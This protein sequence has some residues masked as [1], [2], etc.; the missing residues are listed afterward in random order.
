LF[1][2]CHPE[3]GRRGDRG[4]RICGSY[5]NDKYTPEFRRVRLRLPTLIA[6]R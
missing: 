1:L 6:G 5:F 2:V 3:P 4:R